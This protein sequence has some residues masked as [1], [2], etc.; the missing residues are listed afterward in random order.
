MPIKYTERLDSRG[1]YQATEQI[2]SIYRNYSGPQSNFFET[3]SF[4]FNSTME[5]L[6]K[7]LD[8]FKL[9]INIVNWEIPEDH[10]KYGF[11]T[12]VKKLEDGTIEITITDHSNQMFDERC[13][14]EHFIKIIEREQNGKEKTTL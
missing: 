6:N 8:H 3:N 5:D 12:N 10:R 13:F 7:F 4:T 14:Q 11:F 9:D 1:N 2:A